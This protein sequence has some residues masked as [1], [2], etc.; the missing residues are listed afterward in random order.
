M[1][2]VQFDQLLIQIIP[3]VIILAV[4]VFLTSKVKRRNRETLNKLK[5]Q[6]NEKFEKAKTYNAYLRLGVFG[7]IG[8]FWIG[9]GIFNYLKFPEQSKILPMFIVLI[10]VGLIFIGLRSY[11]V[12][13]NGSANKNEN[14]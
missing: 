9:G 6:D 12:N 2:N 3:A 1:N 8:L 4:M 5:V 11:F 14:K 7:L 13:K 10:G